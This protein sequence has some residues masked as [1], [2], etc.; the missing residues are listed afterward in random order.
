MFAYIGV[1]LLYGEL[2]GHGSVN[3]YGWLFAGLCIA[4][5]AGDT[6]PAAAA[7]DVPQSAIAM[8]PFPNLMR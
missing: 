2:T 6:R 5:A 8:A 3:G 7:N 1:E 4:A